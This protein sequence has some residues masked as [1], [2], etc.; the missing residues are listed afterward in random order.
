MLKMGARIYGATSFGNR[1]VAGG[2]IKNTVFLTT[3]LKATT[4]YS[5]DAVIGE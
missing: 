4:V 1:C 5:G 2:E 3:P